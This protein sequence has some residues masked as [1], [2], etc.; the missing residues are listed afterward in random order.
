MTQ[1]PFNPENLITRKLGSRGII[2]TRTP[3]TRRC[4]GENS[5]TRILHLK[6]L[7]L[8]KINKLINQNSHSH[9]NQNNNIWALTRA[10]TPRVYRKVQSKLSKIKGED[11][12]D[13]IT[14]KDNSAKKR[15][16]DVTVMP[17]QSKSQQEKCKLRTAP[18][19]EIAGAQ[20]CTPKNILRLIVTVN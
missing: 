4:A 16:K 17:R 19:P 1:K 15:K 6:P 8:T 14:T 10:Q 3:V 13:R 5:R 7:S 20:L 11:N 9:T 2:I 12:L 18:E